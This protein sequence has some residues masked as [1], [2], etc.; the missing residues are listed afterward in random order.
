MSVADPEVIDIQISGCLE[1]AIDKLRISGQIMPLTYEAKNNAKTMLHQ[2]LNNIKES[3]NEAENDFQNALKIPDGNKS[4]AGKNLKAATHAF[5]RSLKQNPIGGDIFEKIELDRL[6]L[7]NIL[8]QL[9]DEIGSKNFERLKANVAAEKKNKSEFQSIIKREQESRLAIKDLQKSLVDI[10]IEKEVEIQKRNELIAHLKDRLQELKAKTNMEAKYVK[11]STDNSVAQ[12][13]KKCD[14][15]EIELKQ[16][17]EVGVFSCF[18]IW[19]ATYNHIFVGLF[20]ECPRA[21][22]WRESM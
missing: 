8:T 12:T 9:M 14:L 22:R 6:F 4:N 15:S 11:K 7:E 3:Q 10:K 17:I 18:L 2:S 1:E 5:Q 13:K 16:Q 21:N 20:I 19:V